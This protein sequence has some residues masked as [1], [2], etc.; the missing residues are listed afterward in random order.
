M[1]NQFTE[2]VQQAFKAALRYAQKHLHTEVTGNHLLYSFFENTEGPF[3]SIALSLKLHPKELLSQL[4]EM[5]S[6]LPKFTKPGT[7]PSFSSSLQKTLKSAQELA[8]KWGDA[9]ISSEH[10]FY[11]F[12]QSTQ[13]PF[14]SWKKPS[15][16]SLEQLENYLKNLRGN[17]H[18]DSPT[19]ENQYNALEKYCKNLTQLAK[20]GKLDPVIGRD[21]EIRHTMQVL[22][23]RKK[24]NPLLI[25]EP[26]VGKTAIAEGL[27]L[28][29]VQ[30]D[31]PDALKN[32]ELFALDM[33]SLIAGTKFRGEFEERLKSILKKVEEAE[34]QMILFIDEM[35]TLI[36][37]GATEGAMD[38]ANL[39][40]PALAR[41][42][43][44]CIG[45][46]TLSEY[47]KYIEKDAALER[48]F[49]PILVQEPSL[50]NA[51]AILR[52]LRERYEIHHGVRI[53]E[54]ALHAAVFLSAR[55]ISDRYLPDK[56]IDLIDEAASVIRM[57]ISSRP[58]PIDIKERE[59][60]SLIVKQEGLK[61]ENS[62]L[63]QAEGKKIQE[64]IAQIKE[65]LSLLTNEWNLEKQF[66]E[67]VKQKKN[68]LENLRFQEQE[69]ERKFD[70]NKA[71]EIKY[72]LIPQMTQELEQAQLSL[73]ELPH[74]LL[75]EEV[76]APLI[77]EIV[78]KW[79][80]IPV[81]RM[82][83]EEKMRLLHLETLLNEKVVGQSFAVKAM[84]EAIRRSRSGLNDP[85]RPIGAF[86]FMGPTGVGKTELAKAL[87]EI[88]FDQEDALLRFDMSEYME[89]QSTAKLIGSPPGYI[90]YEEGGQLTEKLRRRPYAVVL[91]DE[92]EKAH[93]EV[94]N[95][96]L[97]V[98]DEG[99]ITDSKGRKVNCK[100]ALFIM[101]SNLG[102]EVLNT[103]LQTQTR[104]PS[105]EEL[106][107][108]LDPVLKT[109]FRPEFRNRL[110]EVLP[111]L[112]LQEKDMEQIVEIQLQKIR[113]RLAEKEVE[114]DYTSEVKALLAKTG[115]DPIYGARPLKRLIQKEVVNLLSNAILEEKIVNHS[116]ITLIVDENGLIGLKI[117]QLG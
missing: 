5:L 116:K 77:A 42:T 11:A 36:G 2:K 39:L 8:D 59:L 14:A 30:G 106:L 72:S 68:A 31:V 112:P 69:A 10:F 100:N 74:R 44:H 28:R 84:S 64:S 9:Y 21:E 17:M 13:E 73:K 3:Y 78:A 19:S 57:Q 58:L 76:D 22:S 1:A 55:Y 4:E 15:K 93:A 70:Y 24:N 6:S 71:A 50:E 90:G 87:A 23:R 40:K 26:G 113:E 7:E 16:L 65:E 94:F 18:S 96:L 86:L 53:T 51:I 102:S 91:F 66:I 63:A 29:I 45:A 88:P 32:R 61:R 105:K 81:Q 114:L 34:G 38:A 115:Y 67:Q 104:Q 33:G 109:H 107:Q 47:K 20:E 103:Y 97:Q 99:H 117:S 52:G 43:L 35:H 46:T 110:D 89:K 92:I 111:F 108:I 79:T 48:R 27:T 60:S 37:A 82:L 80:G 49:Q 85:K 101:T 25:G 12:W 62:P 54:E 98:F 75:Q 83:G 95:L 56:A 41:G